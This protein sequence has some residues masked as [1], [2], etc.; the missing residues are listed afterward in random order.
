MISFDIPTD[1]LSDV[2]AMKEI[3]ANIM[4]PQ[5]R[6]FDEHEH[7]RPTE[8]IN[9]IWPL[10]REAHTQKLA[11]LVKKVVPNTAVLTT[12]LSIEAL[13]WGDAGQYLTRPGGRLGG[14]AIEAVGTPQ[15]KERF[16]SR[17]TEGEPKW[18]SMAITEPD[19]GSDNSSM[20]TTA[21]LDANTN[22][23]ILNGQKIFITSGA[24]SLKESNG[25]CVVWATVDPSAGRK[26]IKSFVVVA[27]S[28]GVDVS[29]GMD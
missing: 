23:W 9:A 7:E 11:G 10:E 1:V 17:F 6:Y 14:T 16:L 4:R 27:N 20:R 29:P 19:A 26:G 24:L 5:S 25:F 22:E 18:G 13:S 15:Q 12:I 28:P 21:V 2:E 3:A 8:F